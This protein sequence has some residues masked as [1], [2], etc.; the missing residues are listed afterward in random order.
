MPFPTKKSV[1]GE[2]REWREGKREGMRMEGK[3][4]RVKRGREGKGRSRG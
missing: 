1:E 2:E 3:R 4:L